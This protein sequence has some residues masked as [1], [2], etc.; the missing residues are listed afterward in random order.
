MS[1]RVCMVN[2]FNKGT[3]IG[4]RDRSVEE[5]ATFLRELGCVVR[6]VDVRRGLGMPTDHRNYDIIHAH[7]YQANVVVHSLRST[8]RGWRSLPVVTTLHGWLWVGLKYRLMNRVERTLIQ[9]ADR[10]FVQSTA[11]AD[12]VRPYLT[13]PVTVRPNGIDLGD[14]TT[15]RMRQGGAF[16]VAMVGRI[17]GEKRVPLGVEALSSLR[18]ALPDATLTIVGPLEDRRQVQAVARAATNGGVARSVTLL[19]QRARPWDW[20]EPDAL[21]I[22]SS[23]EGLPRVMLEAWSRSVPVV[24]SAVGGIP[25][26]MRGQS[27]GWVSNTASPAPSEL[28]ALLRQVHTDRE[29]ARQRVAMAREVVQQYDVR[30][31]AAAY[32]ADYGEILS[33]HRV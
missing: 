12:A 9:R 28:A 13:T 10:V 26:A 20:I 1:I 6:L 16:K 22:S 29:D 4:G 25:E 5:L 7:G 23:T 27:C 24:S 19:G 3:T 18:H 31:V 33:C 8:N 14:L 11:M 30:R 21:L 17:A 2:A 32:L 15:P